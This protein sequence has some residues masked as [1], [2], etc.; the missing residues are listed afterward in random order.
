VGLCLIKV[1]LNDSIEYIGV[2]LEQ[3]EY[4]NEVRPDLYWD[5]ITIPMDDESVDF[6]LA[7]EF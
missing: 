7:T 3:S 4:H 5:G 1:L 2:D 6:V